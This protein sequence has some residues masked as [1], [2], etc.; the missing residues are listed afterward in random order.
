MLG[1]I[2]GKVVSK[3]VRRNIV[4]VA[5]M[6]AGNA[7]YGGVFN[8]GKT[9]LAHYTFVPLLIS[10]FPKRPASITLCI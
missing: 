10:R 9:L 3:I 8:G 5:A 4:P 6:L 2:S 1:S 7:Q